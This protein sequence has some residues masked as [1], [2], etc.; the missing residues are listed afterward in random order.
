MRAQPLACQ[1]LVEIVTAYFEGTLS[2]RDRRRFDAHLGACDGCSAYVEQMR[3]TI[4]LTGTLRE[5][6][7]DPPAREALLHA[8][9]DWRAGPAEQT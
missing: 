4:R 5:E 3:V 9:R 6:D 7:I 1:E 2:R 8:F